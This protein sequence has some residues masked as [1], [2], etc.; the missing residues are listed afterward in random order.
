MKTFKDLKVG[1]K[2]KV[3]ASKSVFVKIEEIKILEV[4]KINRAS[5]DYRCNC[6]SIIHGGLGYMPPTIEVEEII[7]DV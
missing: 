1:D 7:I 2:F 4:K 5:E 3:F 6:V